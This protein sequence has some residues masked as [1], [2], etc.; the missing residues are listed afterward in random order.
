MKLAFALLKTIPAPKKNLLLAILLLQSIVLITAFFDIPIARQ[1]I[2]F[3]Y[4]TFVP[5]FIITK[6]LCLDELDGLETVL[7]SIGLSV[8]FAIFSGLFVNEMLPLLGVS[9]PLSLAPLMFIQSSLVTIGTV[10]VCLR[11]NDLSIFHSSEVFR[12]FNMFNVVS[13]CLPII[14]IAGAIY[15]E[16]YESNLLLLFLIILISLFFSIVVIRKKLVTSNVYPF[17]IL[18]IAI[19]LLYH[20]SM[21]S[22]YIVSFGSD[23]PAEFLVFRVTQNNAHWDSIFPLSG[24]DLG[25]GRLNAMLSVTILPTVYST[26]LNLDPNLL[27]KMLFPAIF[28][29][30]PVCLYKLWQPSLGKKGAFVAAFLFMAQDYFYTESLG[31]SRQ[32]IAEL[33]FVLLL[34]VIFSKKIKPSGRLVCFTT[35]SL[36]LVVSHYGLAEIFLFFF[37]AAS[38]Y[39]IV[40]KRHTRKITV[41]MVILFSVIMFSWYLYTSN[42]TVFESFVSFGDNVAQQLNQ[43]LNPESRGETVL[44]GLGLTNPSTIWNLFSRVFAYLTEAF[45]VVGFVAVITKRTSRRFEGEQIIFFTV[46]ILSL[47]LLIIVPGLANTLGMTRFYHL[48]LFFLAALFVLGAEFLSKLAFKQGNMQKLAVSILLLSIVVPY[49]L[50]QSGFVY[51]VTGSQSYSLPLSKNQI[52]S[53]FLRSHFG[54]FNEHEVFGASWLPKYVDTRNSIIYSDLSSAYGVLI[55]YGMMY[56]RYLEMLSNVTTFP[57]N[58]V[59]YLNEPNVIEKVVFS[60]YMWNITDLSSTFVFTDKVYS[61]G[62]CEIYKIP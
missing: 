44:T 5:G 32:I 38:A 51:T 61:N 24:T 55:D 4:F 21:I 7:F 60:G 34:L 12:S 25:Y 2:G 8:A 6:L 10:V 18:M 1:I 54:Y 35:F 46:T 11:S 42:A 17:A 58:S 31:L 3:L 30:V 39:L 49:F 14:S 33:F 47:A 27:F 50:F 40:T 37:L 15:A 48:M 23:V 29:L 26:L 19:A 53:W 20:A 36:G 57:Q 56:N 41:P 28:S 13:L 22:K 62:E 9:E 16:T 52:S 59:I 45:I 43:F